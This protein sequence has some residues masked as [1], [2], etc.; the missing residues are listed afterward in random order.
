MKVV[1]TISKILV[2]LA[3]IALIVMI[4]LFGGQTSAVQ[5]FVADPN[6]QPPTN[7]STTDFS[8]VR[9][10]LDTFVGKDVS[11][12]SVQADLIKASAEAYRTACANAKSA[13][14]MYLFVNCKTT[15]MPGTILEIP[16]IGNRY[17][18]KTGTEFYYTEYS[19]PGG[20][21]GGL[22]GAFAPEN[23]TF[24]LRSYSDASIMDYVYSEKSLSPQFLKADDGSDAVVGIERYWDDPEKQISEDKWAKEQLQGIYCSAQTGEYTATD[25]NITEETIKSAQIEYKTSENGNYYILTLELDTDNPKTTER[26]IDNLRKGANSEDANYTSMVETIEIWENGYFKYFKSLDEWAMHGKNGGMSSLI[27]YETTFYFDAAHTDPTIYMDFA[28]AKTNALA[29]NSTRTAE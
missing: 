16:V 25:Q 12:A 22:A 21:L 29:Y 10:K 27:D 6:E 8:S 2:I 3:L 28:E 26:S 9:A 23:T 20:G 13:E 24:A 19:I 1:A 7:S 15:M 17:V 11:S 14:N 5:T 4:I 18:L